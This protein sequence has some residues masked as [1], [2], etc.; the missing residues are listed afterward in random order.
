M[1]D[2]GPDREPLLAET[3]RQS[4]AQFETN[5]SDE[6]VLAS[7]LKLLNGKTDEEK[8]AGLMVVVKARS[9]KINCNS[10]GE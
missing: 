10:Q 4:K 1:T 6:D 2:A 3:L 5:R 9:Q 8:F 7:A